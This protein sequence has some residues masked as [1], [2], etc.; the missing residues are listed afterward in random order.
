MLTQ[1]RL[2]ELLTYNENNGLFFWNK[3]MENSVKKGDFAGYLRGKYRCIRIDSKN[4]S[5]HR[6]AWLYIYGYF[7]DKIDHINGVSDDN[8]IVNLRDVN[9][10]ENNKNKR[11]GKNNTSGYFGVTW[12]KTAKKWRAFIKTDG[13]NKHLGYHV[14]KEDAIKCRK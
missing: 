7:P 14:K 12:N 13:K 2:K 11:L 10:S 6:L 9:Y 5:S 8:R 3:D 1:N 4:Y